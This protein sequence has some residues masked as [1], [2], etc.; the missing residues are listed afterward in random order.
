MATPQDLEAAIDAVLNHR[1]GIQH[2]QANQSIA[3]KIYEAYVFSLC[4][5][6]ILELDN[7]LTLHGISSGQLESSTP[8]VFRGGPGQIHSTTRDYGYAKFSLGDENYEIHS[9]I[10][11]LRLAGDSPIDTGM[12]WAWYVE[13]RATPR[14]PLAGVASGAGGR[15]GCTVTHAAA[16]SRGW[17]TWSAARARRVKVCWLR[18]AAVGSIRPGHRAAAPWV[19]TSRRFTRRGG[20]P[21]VRGRASAR[22]LALTR[23]AAEG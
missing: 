6:A 15:G 1:L 4:L 17:G 22:S 7:S 16:G 20:Q 18:P 13:V 9:G 8:F 21:P 5:R 12:E 23:S 2:F 3:G 10:E 14:F 11:C 19:S